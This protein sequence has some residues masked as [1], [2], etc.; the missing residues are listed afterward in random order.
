MVIVQCAIDARRCFSTQ[1][2]M[3]SDRAVGTGYNGY[4]PLPQM[5]TKIGELTRSEIWYMIWQTVKPQ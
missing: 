5:Q 3:N 4:V 1:G 2:V